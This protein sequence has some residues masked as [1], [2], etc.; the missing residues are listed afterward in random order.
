MAERPHSLPPLSSAVRRPE[1]EEELGRWY[2]LDDAQRLE[3]LREALA[4]RREF[5]I[6]ALAHI[7][8]RALASGD[9]CAFDLA[10][11]ALSKRAAPL[12]LWQAGRLGL[13][14]DERRETAHEVLI[15]F[16]EAI[17]DDKAD[18]AESNFGVF[19]L[20][21]AI[22][23][24]RKKKPRRQAVKRETKPAEKADPL[25]SIPVRDPSPEELALL[26]HGLDKLSAKQ[27]EVI[28]QYYLLGM[29][30]QEIAEHHG[31]TVRT[32]YNRLKTASAAMGLSG[33]GDAP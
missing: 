15:H 30:Q 25:E 12:L 28:I 29:T 31:V 7:N 26:N 6:E 23:L 5:S 8:R 14:G 22:S 17:R 9:R 13:D 16:W 20:R 1:V 27:R 11:E 18:F 10:F 4:G 24:C 21:A 33:G 19:A 3:A 2:A 32:V